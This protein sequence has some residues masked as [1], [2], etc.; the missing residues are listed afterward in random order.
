MINKPRGYDM[1]AA[2]DGSRETLQPGGYICRILGA[3]VEK[4]QA[5]GRLAEKLVLKIDIDD[6]PMA[7]F[8]ARQQQR[9]Q[10]MG[11]SQ[12]WR[13]TFD[14]F[15]ETQ[16]GMCNPFF[17]GLIKCVESSNPNFVWN[18]DERALTNCKI[19][20]VFGEERYTGSDGKAHSTVRARMARSVD[21]I[22]EGVEAP[23]VLDRTNSRSQAQEAKQQA[24]GTY[25]EDELPF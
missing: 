21:A 5:K 10:Q 9:A 12:R 14:V 13:G 18:W 24:S 16:E 20:I 2:Y 7:G 22:K 17:K 1:A 25:V 8:F 4:V 23:Q 6:G 11:G 19:G 15:I 3:N